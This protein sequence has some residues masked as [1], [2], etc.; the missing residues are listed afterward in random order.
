MKFQSYIRILY[1]YNLKAT[2]K[3]Y[4]Y[5]FAY[6]IIYQ[7]GSHTQTVHGKASC[8]GASENAT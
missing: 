1:I 8:R 2:K 7:H 3:E 6:S 5:K 4:Q